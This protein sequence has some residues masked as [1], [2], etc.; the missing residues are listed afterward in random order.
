MLTYKPKRNTKRA[1]TVE[2]ILFFILVMLMLISAF[3][4]EN[5][6]VSQA[7]LFT[8][9]AAV[10]YI[11]MRYMIYEYTYAVSDELFEVSRVAG[12]VPHLI[13]RIDISENDRLVPFT[14]KKELKNEGV[15][16]FE[17]TCA[18][19]SPYPVYAYITELDEKKRAILLECDELFAMAV[20]ERINMKK[21][22]SKEENNGI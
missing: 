9:V 16:R 19:L 10:I 12:R 1:V 18:N 8:V 5:T 7:I 22:K 14:S 13:V 15:M 20:S 21:L 2:I 6:L 4:L 11:A 3:G 17:N